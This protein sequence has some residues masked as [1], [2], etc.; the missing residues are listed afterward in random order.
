MRLDRMMRGRPLQ[1][2]LLRCVGWAAVA[3]ASLHIQ[4]RP[5]PAYAESAR[6]PKS[7]IQSGYL[8]GAKRCGQGASA[9]PKLRIGM[10][11]G[12]CAGLVA[13]EHDGL[14]FPRNIVQVP[15]KEL[16]VVADMGLGWSP[17]KG[18]LLLLDPQAPE[19]QRVKVLMT[20]VDFP[21]GLAVGIDRRIYAS[22]DQKVFRFDPL[23]DKPESTIE[24]I[25]QGLPG[26]RVTLSD[27]T[28]I[29]DSEHPLKHFVFDRTGRIFLNVGAPTD[30]CTSRGAT[31]SKPCAAGEGDAP[32]ASIWTYAPPAGGIFPALQPRSQSAARDLRA[33]PAQLDGAR[34]PSA[35]PRPR[36]RVLP[37]RERP[38][39]A[40]GVATERG[41]QSRREGQALWLAVLL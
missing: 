22:T 13:S 38:R 32:F 33:R 30:S 6:A 4:W 10:Q 20:R 27:G 23:A 34:H 36:L 5:T 28:R 19:G 16:F 29:A 15:D 11:A 35:V 3:I 24:V 1:R 8:V 39:S 18:R 40:G 37:G 12:Y 31:E 9:F 26:R 14:I 21:H 17:G 41:A 25:L 7:A 2:R